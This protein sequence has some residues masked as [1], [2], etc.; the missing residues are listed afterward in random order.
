MGEKL[1]SRERLKLLVKNHTSHF[2]A[3]ILNF[4]D[5]YHTL[6]SKIEKEYQTE[7]NAKEGKHGNTGNS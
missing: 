6:I 7:L 3:I 1:S 5:E 2:N 4:A